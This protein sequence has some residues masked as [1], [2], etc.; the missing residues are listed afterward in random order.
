MIIKTIGD[1]E[2]ITYMNNIV[3]Y[4]M[5][6][7]STDELLEISVLTTDRGPFE[8]DHALVLYF[9][10]LVIVIPSEHEDY[11]TFFFDSLTKDFNVDYTE[12]I[13]A[14]GCTDNA[15]FLLWKAS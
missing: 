7:I 1:N 11:K 8:D 3:E 13:K 12:Y 4:G 14:M 6:K 10:D 5:L 9:R 15:E 2:N